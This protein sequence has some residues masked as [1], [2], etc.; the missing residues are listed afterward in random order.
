MVPSYPSICSTSCC[1]FTA[2]CPV[3][4][5]SDTHRLV[6]GA[7]RTAPAEDSAG[8]PL[9][10]LRAG[11]AR[12]EIPRTFPCQMCSLWNDVNLVKHLGTFISEDG[13]HL[14]FLGGYKFFSTKFTKYEPMEHWVESS[15][16]FSGI[17]CP[18]G[19][20]GSGG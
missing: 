2:R 18:T 15:S 4:S 20:G 10:H 5:P 16:F 13:P 7:G 11:R 1:G 8:R 12:G 3:E 14:T 9:S 19:R 6:R 17:S